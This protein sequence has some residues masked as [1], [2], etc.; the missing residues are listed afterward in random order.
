MAPSPSFDN[1]RVLILES[2]RAKEMASIVSSYGGQPI[3]APSMREVPLESNPEAIAFADALERDEFDLVILLTGVF[4][5]KSLNGVFDGLIAGNPGQV[6]IQAV[7][8]LTAIVFSG[9]VTFIL[10]K[11]IGLFIPLRA[12]VSD[13]GTGLDVT[14]H[15]EE[16]YL[17]GGE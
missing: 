13:E 14:M 4:A 5:E 3:A 11:V 9:G 15:G 16:A 1:R 12:T 7:A 17:H 8:V 10:L 2:R 6:G